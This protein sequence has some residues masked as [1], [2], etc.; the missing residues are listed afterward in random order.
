MPFERGLQR[1]PT[2]GTEA[3]CAESQALSG[4]QLRRELARAT[5]SRLH[6]LRQHQVSIPSQS[7]SGVKGFAMPLS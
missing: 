4:L 2:Q 7:S 5:T 1:M 3:L 6:K